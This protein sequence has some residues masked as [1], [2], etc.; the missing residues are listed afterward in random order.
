MGTHTITMVVDPQNMITEANENNNAL[1]ESIEVIELSNEIE[2]TIPRNLRGTS[3]QNSITLRWDAAT[4]FY[5]GGYV[6]YRDGVRQND[7]PIALTTYTDT[8]LPSGTLYHYQVTSVDEWGGNESPKSNTLAISTV[9]DNIDLKVDYKDV[10]ITPQDAQTGQTVTISAKIHNLGTDPVSNVTVTVYTLDGPIST[11]NVPSIGAGGEYIVQ[12]NWI[13]TDPNELIYI[14][15]DPENALL[16]MDEFNNLAITSVIK[17]VHFTLIDQALKLGYRALGDLD[18]DGDLDVLNSNA[19]YLGVNDGHGNFTYLTKDQ[20]G[21]RSAT[22]YS[23]AFGDVDNDGFLDV[24]ICN[25]WA[26]DNRLYKNNGNLTFT[27][28]TQQANLKSINTYTVNAVF[29]DLNNDGKLDLFVGAY[30]G[31]EYIYLNNGN[32]TFTRVL[33]TIPDGYENA[34]LGD[35]NGDGYLDAVVCATDAIIYINDGTG[36]FTK[37]QA[38]P[39]SAWDVAIGDMDNDGYL[40]IITLNPGRVFYNDGNGNFSSANSVLLPRYG[41]YTVNVADFDNDGDLDILYSSN[42]YLLRNDGNRKFTDISA[43]FNSTMPSYT[44]V[45]GD[46]DNDGDIDIIGAYNI[47]RNE[48]NNS[49]Y[50]IFSLRGIQS[51]YYGIGSKISVYEEGHLGEGSYLKGFRQVQAGG[52]GYVSQDSSDAHFGVNSN[53]KYDVQVIFPAS[54]IVTNRRS[55]IPGRKLILPEYGDLYV[56]PEDITFSHEAPVDGD[57]LIV[58]ALIHNPT[59]IDVDNVVVGFYDGN[60]SAG[61]MELGRVELPYVPAEGEKAFPIQVVLSEGFHEIYV[62]IDPDNVLR[63]TNKGNNIASRTVTVAPRLVDQD[64]SISASDIGINPMAP[65]EGAEVSLSAIVHSSGTRDMQNVPVAFYDGDPG[66]GG[67][68]IG[69]TIIPVLL[70]SGEAQTQVQ[71]NTLGRSGLHYIHVLVDPLNLIREVNESNNSALVAVDVIFP[72]KP[73]LAITSSDIVLSSINPNEGETL[74]INATVHSL[75][76]QTGNV[77]ASLYDGDPLAGG[78]LLA[79][80][81]HMQIIPSGGAAVFTFEVDTVGLSGIHN[82]FVSVDPDN[83]I[84]EML[85]SNNLASNSITI[86]QAGLSLG[87]STDKSVYTANEDVQITVNLNNLKSIDRTGTLEVKI[88]DENSNLVAAVSSQGITLGPNEARTLANLWNTGQTLSGGYKVASQFSEGG[89]I[90]SRAEVPITIAPVKNISSRVATDKITYQV[91]Q[92]VTITST[93]T[94]LS[95]N[96][97]FSNLNARIRIT[98]SQAAILLTDLKTIPLLTPNQVSTL[99][100][101]WNTASHPKGPY[102]ATLEVLDGPILLSA[103]QTTFTITGSSE[104]GAGLTGTISAQPS[105]IYQGLE[106]AIT[107]GVTNNGNEDLTEVTVRVLIV[108]PDTQEVKLTFDNPA[109]LPAGG[110]MGQ[111]FAFST[112]PFAPHIYLAILQAVTATMPEPKTL[113]SVAF[114]VKPG[115]Q[116]TKTI[117]DRVNLLVWVNDQCGRHFPTPDTRCHEPQPC[118]RVDLLERILNEAAVHYHIVYNKDDFETEMRNPYYTD[119]MILGDHEPLT[120]H[121]GDELREQVYSGKGLLSSL[122]IKHGQCF[123]NEDDSVFGLTYRGHLPGFSHN[124]TIPEGPLSN[125]VSFEAEGQALRVDV[126]DPEQI[127][128][129][130][131]G[132]YPA[133]VKNQYGRG[134]TLF[135]AFDIGKTLQDESYSILSTILKN[136]ILSIHT[137]ADAEAFSSYQLVPILLTVK[138]LGGTF[139]IRIS[140]TYPEELKLHDPATGQS[141]IDHPWVFD[142]YINP[143]ETKTIVYDALTPDKLGAY[144][145]QTEVGYLENGVYH[146][147][148]TLCQDIVVG[149][150]TANMAGDILQKLNALSVSKHDDLRLNKAIFHIERVQHRRIKHIYDIEENI[151]D[152]LKAIDPLISMTST[153]ISEVRLLIDAFLE[154]WEAKWYFY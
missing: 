111:N 7:I 22:D 43:L 154:V 73:D 42:G 39:G 50:L 99:K 131:K 6:V 71:W 14:Q 148:Q 114:E 88:L 10:T 61:G 140:E 16:E 134:K 117:A 18:N 122:Y 8:G 72:T 47:Y 113:A 21:F 121:H 145:L 41:G 70:A 116:I 141:I 90:I 86:G 83:R 118:L 137:P 124:I 101:Y 100:T 53:Y 153:D 44:I 112:A 65:W 143:G 23:V 136:S 125:A 96:F 34:E 67:V 33:P 30:G 64:L 9:I 32:G 139:D 133:I 60:P 28:I 13:V 62:V 95:P 75:G 24:F 79:R 59:T 150:D 132:K 91:N 20:T 105:W 17:N 29:G 55:T 106:E 147:Y 77:D 35:L 1:S 109:V 66:Q 85:E 98:N 119:F 82:L 48:M 57:S 15:I 84:D 108:D 103:S 78:R 68:L 38:L 81:S 11:A 142:I 110:S 52:Q 27:D 93:I 31:G 25:T 146:Y 102:T 45:L 127:L 56:N 151:Q 49:N 152:I 40:D 138:N 36:H 129:W 149:K 3:T 126:N 115:F 123:E 2:Q 104:T 74:T 37:Q 80:S 76:L 46:I 89:N 87:L 144:T 135:Y 54:G 92:V 4:R 94:S 5:F 26:G 63:E 107:Y 51:N 58:T 19:Y 128:G 130:I 97:I 120:D 69:Q 12:M